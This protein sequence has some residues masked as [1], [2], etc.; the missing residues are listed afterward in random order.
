MSEK[1]LSDNDPELWVG[2]TPVPYQD[3]LAAMDARVNALLLGQARELV[4]LLEHPPLYTAGT[5]AVAG[6]LVD[7]ERFPVHITGRGG[8]HTYHGPGQRVAYVV[9]DLAKRDHDLKAHVSRLEE[10]VIRVLDSF[11]VK[12]ERRTGRIGIW[13]DAAGTDQK[14]AAIGVR[15]RRWVTSHGLALNVNPDLAHFEG[16]IPCG[17]KEYGVTSLHALGVKASMGDVDQAF[18]KKFRGVFS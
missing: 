11:G 9:M 14:I 1:I 18:Q 4:W 10:W 16:I 2:Q 5:S 3:A 7:P 12:G 6:D 15:A 17:I 13:V 8:K